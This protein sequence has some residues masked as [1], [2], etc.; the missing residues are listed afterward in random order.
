MFILELL[1]LLGLPTLACKSILAY[2]PLLKGSEAHGS[3]CLDQ[4][5]QIAVE[6]SG[7]H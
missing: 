4:N 2:L 6:P 5:M 3:V 1:Q 7:E